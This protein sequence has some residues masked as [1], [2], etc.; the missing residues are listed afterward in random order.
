MAPPSAEI[1]SRSMPRAATPQSAA[2]EEQTTAGLLTAAG[3]SS[4]VQAPCAQHETAEMP[5]CHQRALQ[6]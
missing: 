3:E 5:G 4:A 2:T 6:G 1:V